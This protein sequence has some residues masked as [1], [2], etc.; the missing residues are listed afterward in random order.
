[1]KPPSLALMRVL[2]PLLLLG[3][4]GVILWQDKPVSDPISKTVSTTVNLTQE[5]FSAAPIGGL[6]QGWEAPRGTFAVALNDGRKMLK[7]SP[8]PMLE[9][10]VLLPGLLTGGG[11]IRARMQG[12]QG[13]RTFPRFGV[14][15][16]ESLFYKLQALPGAK[17]LRLVLGE[18]F[19]INGQP[20][21]DDRELASVPW[22]WDP[23]AW[24]WVELSVTPKGTGS[25]WEG[26]CWADGTSRPAEP[27]L[28]YATTTPPKLVHATLQ[29]APYALKPI[30]IDRVETL[31][32]DRP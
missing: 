21:E 32:A 1:M 30:F 31:R 17:Q 6:P 24:C 29:V 5:D 8:E 22:I 27:M 11:T 9:G 19:E 28:T 13:K 26:R 10:R 4:L 2:L 25:I 14:G 15:L 18:Q 16:G 12:E 23:E 20:A 3:G 7:F